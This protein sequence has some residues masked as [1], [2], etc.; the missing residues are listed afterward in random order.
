MGT[1]VDMLPEF[2]SASA[3]KKADS[4]AAPAFLH[5]DA[6]LTAGSECARLLVADD[7]IWDFA[8]SSCGG[9][10]RHQCL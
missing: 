7:V 5:I 6:G 9:A 3:K 1:V 10:C 4:L 2:R 8:D